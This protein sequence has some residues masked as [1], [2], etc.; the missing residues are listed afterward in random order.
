MGMR[1]RRQAGF[2][3]VELIIVM[4]IIA[5]IAAIGLPSLLQTVRNQQSGDVATK[6]VQDLAWARGEAVSGHTVTMALA[7]DGSWVVTEDGNTVNDHSLTAT[8]VQADAPG[9]TCAVAGGNSCLT[10]P[11]MSF[12][13][14]GMVSNQPTGVITFSSGKLS[15]TLQIFT[16][17]VV[18]TNVSN[19]S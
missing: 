8:Q 2:T 12:D 7:A 18:V 17:G 5:I 10:S 6:F 13:T 9:L 11:A 16:S 3:M 19:A 15:S 4:L 14:Q 1:R